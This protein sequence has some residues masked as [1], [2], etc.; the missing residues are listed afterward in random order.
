MKILRHLT[1][2]GP[3]YA[4]L[5]PDGTAREVVGDILGDYRLTGRVITPG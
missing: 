1:P 4:A 5:Q 2:T 3:A